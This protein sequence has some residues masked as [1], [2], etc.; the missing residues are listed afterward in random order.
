M[1]GESSDY[2]NATGEDDIGGFTAREAMRTPAFWLLSMGHS[3]ALLTVGAVSLHLVP[4]IMET[5]GLSITAASTA[6]AVMTVFNI[7]GQVG[8]GVVSDRFSKRYMAAIAMLVHCAGLIILANAT[9]IIPVYVFAVLHGTAWG[10]RGP[11]MTTIRAD[12]FG[13]ASFA[14][15]MGFSSLVVML[16]MTGGP[17]FAGFMADIFDGYRI[18]FM[19]IAAITGLGCFFFAIARPPKPPARLSR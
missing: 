3:M 2:G 8:G 18:P 7:I 15:I 19:I 17:L 10:V 13:R 1:S 5:V 16:G 9:T 11:L 4:H 6:V 14:T 12:Y